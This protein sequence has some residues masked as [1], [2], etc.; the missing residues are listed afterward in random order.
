MIHCFLVYDRF[1][2]DL[3][4]GNVNGKNGPIDELLFAVA[5]QANIQAK[6]EYLI[7]RNALINDILKR[8]EFDGVELKTILLARE[9][10]LVLL[11]DNLKQN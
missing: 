11:K 8:G 3:T 2:V 5:V 7:Y 10:G 9:E 1:R 4:E 6:E